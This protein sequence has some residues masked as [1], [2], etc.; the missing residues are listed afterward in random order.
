MWFYEELA[1]GHRVDQTIARRLESGEELGNQRG[2]IN[3]G[4]L[5]ERMLLF[6]KQR[7]P[8][9]GYL[10]PFAERRMHEDIQ[11][12]Q[13][14]NISCAVL[15]DASGS[16][17]VAV[18]TATILG[19]LLALCLNADLCFFNSDRFT[20]TI[21]SGDGGPT[22]SSPLSAEESLLVATKVRAEGGTSPAAALMH[23]TVTRQ[24]IDLFICVTDEEENVADGNGDYFAEA[25]WRYRNKVNSSARVIL[26][27]FLQPHNQGT[28]KQRLAEI[29]FSE[30]DVVQFRMDAQRPDL[31]KFDSLLG[32]VALTMG[33]KVEPSELV[34]D[35]TGENR[36]DVAA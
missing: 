32:T 3:Y 31:S 2:R 8:F 33:R 24:P 18:E 11:R 12:Y 9:E 36:E 29:G 16:M 14:Q 30:P 1:S 15:G 7:K 27:S 23:Y 25:F 13:L 19:S 22:R 21:P 28:M 10:L 26:V 4:K 6:R 17:G 34:D 20:A 5:M 35:V